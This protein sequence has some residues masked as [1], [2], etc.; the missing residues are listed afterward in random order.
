MAGHAYDNAFKILSDV[1]TGLNEYT[2]A[3]WQGTQTHGKY[4]NSWLLTQIN[5]AQSRIYSLM[6]KTE[7]K[8]IFYEEASITGSSSVFTL[9]WDFGRL[10]QFEDAQGYKVHPTSAK[11]TPVQGAEGSKNL[12][13]RDGRTLIVTK[14]GVSDTY[15]LKYYKIPRRMTFG[16]AATSSG[17]NDLR[18]A[19]DVTSIR[20]DD[21][22][23]GLRIDNY[24]Q[25]KTATISDYV[26]STRSAT[27]NNSITW[28]AS[29]DYYGTVSDLPDEVHHLIAPLAI[30][31]AKA[32][33]P[34]SQT[35]PTKTEIGMWGEMLLESMIAF[36]Q[37]PE[38]IP[39]ED[40]FC[41]F[42]P[43]GGPMVHTL[44]G[45]DWPVFG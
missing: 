1:R 39:I 12:Y 16:L 32:T 45:H 11:Y 33:H 37:E 18:L 38:D 20:L 13:Y 2:D 24:T 41:D 14:S 40:I 42:G 27:T 15:T 22:Y 29:T 36:V 8:T 5:N 31:L 35:P 26:A 21:Y 3:L 6:M 25:A 23:N 44:P 17:S 7:A 19:D 43:G 28:V 30:I 34:A 4:S 9:P 10:L